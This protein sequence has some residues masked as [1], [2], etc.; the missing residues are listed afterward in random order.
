MDKP[1][2]IRILLL[3]ILSGGIFSDGYVLAN[4]SLCVSAVKRFLHRSLAEMLAMFQFVTQTT[5]KTEEAWREI[6]LIDSKGTT[7]ECSGCGTVFRKICLFVFMIVHI[8]V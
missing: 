6:V 3:S 5:V 8:A 7:Q 2:L 4:L 1:F